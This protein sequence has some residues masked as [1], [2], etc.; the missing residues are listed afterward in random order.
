MDEI[1]CSFYTTTNYVQRTV[2]S[3]EIVVFWL[4]NREILRFLQDVL[5]ITITMMVN[6]G[7]LRELLKI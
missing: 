5:V 2:L 6:F 1:Q 4:T 7:L 3:I